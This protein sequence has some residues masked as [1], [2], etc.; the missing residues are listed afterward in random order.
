MQSYQ[1]CDEDEEDDDLVDDNHVMAMV[2]LMATMKVSRRSLPRY[3]VC[4]LGRI[5]HHRQVD[6]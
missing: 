5:F 6:R 2:M 1:V 4:R 3:V